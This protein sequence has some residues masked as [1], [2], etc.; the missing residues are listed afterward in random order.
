MLKRIAKNERGLTLVELLAVIVILGIIAAIAVPAIGGLIN[1]TDNKATVSE[2]IQIINGAKLYVAAEGVDAVPQSG[3]T[4]KELAEYV[5][6]VKDEGY[7]VIVTRSGNKV[8]YSIKDH[9]A[10]KIVN[11]DPADEADL[12]NFVGKSK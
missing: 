12:L 7:T 6:N 3:L 9:K 10:C 4:S 8:S 1:K 5:D 11:K 2:A